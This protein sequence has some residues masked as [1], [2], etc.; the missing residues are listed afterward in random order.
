MLAAEPRWELPVLPVVCHALRRFWLSGGSQGRRRCGLQDTHGP[1]LPE[2]TEPP[3]QACSPFGG[4]PGAQPPHWPRTLCFS[5][6]LT[7]IL[8]RFGSDGVLQSRDLGLNFSRCCH[9]QCGGKQVSH[10]EAIHLEKEQREAP[11]LGC[12]RD[13]GPAGPQAGGW[14]R[15]QRGDLH[16]CRPGLLAQDTWRPR[17]CLPGLCLCLSGFPVWAPWDGAS[18]LGGGCAL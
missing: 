10:S 3:S 5:P 17:F 18:L 9:P 8:T 11:C 14:S 16:L 2:I 12:A 7:L 6:C 13:T 15:P 4:D 1:V